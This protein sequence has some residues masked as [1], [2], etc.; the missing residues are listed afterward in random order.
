[1][2]RGRLISFLRFSTRSRRTEFVVVAFSSGQGDGGE[3]GL[4]RGFGDRVDCGVGGGAL[5]QRDGGRRWRHRRRGGR[6]FLLRR[7]RQAEIKDQAEE[8]E[9]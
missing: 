6:E 3:P 2:T 9:N 7:K 1:M 8:V 5:M 4:G